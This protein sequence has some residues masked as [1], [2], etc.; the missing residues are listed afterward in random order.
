MLNHG[1]PQFWAYQI[2]AYHTQKKQRR[3]DFRGLGLHGLGNLDVS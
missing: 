2:C 1:T 3:I